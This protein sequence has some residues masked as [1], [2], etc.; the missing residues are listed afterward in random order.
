M[1]ALLRADRDNT[2]QG[3]MNGTS[4]VTFPEADIFM[5]PLN[6]RFQV[7]FAMKFDTMPVGTIA[8]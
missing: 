8:Q 2:G 3:K 4:N 6:S 1:G 5:L 7:H